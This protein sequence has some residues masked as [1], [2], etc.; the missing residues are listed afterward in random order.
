MRKPAFCL[1]E[2]KDAGQL[3]GNREADQ[4]LCLRYID[5]TISLLSKSEISSLLPSCVTAQPVLCQTRSETRKNGFLSKRLKSKNFK[6]DIE[7]LIKSYL[8]LPMQ[9][10]RDEHFEPRKPSIYVDTGVRL[11]D[12]GVQ[13]DFSIFWSKT[14][15]Y[16][17]GLVLFFFFLLLALETISYYH[18]ENNL[19][20][21]TSDFRSEKQ[22]NKQQII[23]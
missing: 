15:L 22:T 9:D 11:A 2:N 4:R 16:I 6:S 1:C 17:M 20:N 7:S 10:S 3:R 14:W 18:Y 21:E 5:T 19:I 13:N 12:V 8:E 23:T